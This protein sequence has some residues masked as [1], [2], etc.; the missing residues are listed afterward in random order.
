MLLGVAPHEDDPGADALR[1]REAADV[2]AVVRR[3][4]SERWPVF[5]P[6]TGEWRDPRLGD[7]C[8]LLPARTS[9]G[10]LERSLDDAGIPYRAET[11]SLV[12]GS[13][14]IRELLAALRGSGRSERQ[15]VARHRVAIVA[16]RLR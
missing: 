3:V 6:A 10:F 8:I 12:Y 15:L 1:L 14:E 16:V 9:L 2:A 5:E 11:S 4:I 13:R 7:V